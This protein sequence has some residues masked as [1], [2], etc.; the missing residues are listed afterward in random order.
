MSSETSR[1]RPRL[2]KYCKGNGLDIGY[3]GDPIVSDAITID[4]RHPYARLGDVPKNLAGDARDL[5]W[6]KDGVLDYVYSSHLLEDFEDTGAVLREWLRV[7]KYGG[8]FVLFGPDE[9]IYK[10]HC[11]QTGQPY[12]HGHKIADFGLS[13]VKSI[14]AQINAG[15]IIH[16]VP[17]IDDYNFELVI[18][19]K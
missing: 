17:L 5:R 2:A 10:T 14:L 8:L 7:L 4:L 19:K 15:E 6:F 1:C 18:R 9:Q 12:N 16:E 3:G 11:R 13:Y